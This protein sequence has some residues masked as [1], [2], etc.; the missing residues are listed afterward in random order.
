MISY[1]ATKVESLYLSKLS[2]TKALTAAIFLTFIFCFSFSKVQAVVTCN[3]Y[4]STTGNDST[5]TGSSTAPFKTL[6]K[7]ESVV[8]AGKTVCVQSGTYLASKIL[9]NVQGTASAP[10]IFT[11]DPSTTG[12][13]ILDGTGASIGSGQSIINIANT[14]YVTFDGFEVVNSPSNGINVSDSSNIIVSNN[15]IHEIQ[16]S[17]S[18][19]T[20]T[21]ITFTQNEVYNSSMK[22]LNNAFGSG[23]WPGTVI[24]WIKSDGTVS[25]NVQFTK[26][27]IHDNWGEGIIAL[28]LDGGVIE[29]NVVRDNFGVLLYVDRAKNISVNSNYVVQT[30]D[31]RNRGSLRPDG[32]LAAVESTS[33]PSGIPSISNVTISNNVV[34][35]TN[36]GIGY[37]QD[38]ENT[39]SNNTYSG[40]KMY[41]NVIKD[42]KNTP[43]WIDI[44]GNSYPTPS[45]SEIRNN[46]V[47]KGANGSSLVLG[48]LN[49]WTLS[50]NVWPDGIPAPD[51]ETKGSLAG[52]PL[53]I[54]PPSAGGPYPITPD[55]F[56]L[57]ASS[58]ARGKGVSVAV[59]E[60]YYRAVRPLSN[61]DIGFAQFT[62]MDT[63]TPTV[64]PT[65]GV[66]C[67]GDIDKNGIVDLKDYAILVK[68]FL[69]PNPNLNADLNGNGRV[70]IVDYAILVKNFLR[71][72]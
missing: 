35:G 64:S 8:T 48:N 55:G 52:D 70:D 30:N 61:T 14:Q 37:W 23:G 18:V 1:P 47:Y 25:K 2:L 50:N 3:I 65:T 10:I 31:I 16:S 44:V 57:Q 19:M 27:Y 12:S 71:M 29:E 38:E 7:A 51:S 49:A 9:I 21:N 17:A 36:Y 15:K 43:V 69:V 62:S 11:K 40:L 34:L 4:V 72:C 22:N 26:N 39:A 56:K 60:D 59:T 58:L 68:N 46:I 42:T 66:V 41:Y 67:P 32:I 20:G 45:S 6:N 54:S 13:V 5:G 28:F 33:N 24:T 63:I 53:F